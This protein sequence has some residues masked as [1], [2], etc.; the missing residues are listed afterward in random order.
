LGGNA[1]II[2]STASGTIN[3]TSTTNAT[4]TLTGVVQI[5]G[6]QSI[7]KDIYIGGKVTC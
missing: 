4:D 5:A 7:V 3:V 6:G 2:N 1:N